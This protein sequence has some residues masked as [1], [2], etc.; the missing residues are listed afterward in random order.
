MR[1]KSEIQER[2]AATAREFWDLLSPEKPLFQG[3]PKVIHRGQADATWPLVPKLFRDH[4]NVSRLLARGTPDANT[5]MFGE[6][7]Y[8]ADFV[9]HCDSVGLTIPNDSLEFRTKYFDQNLLDRFFSPSSEWPPEGLVEL[10]ALAQHHGLPTRLLDWTKRSYVAAYFAASDALERGLDREPNSDGRF[11]V[12]ALSTDLGALFKELKIVPVPGSNNAN[13][14][15]QAGLFTILRLKNVAIRK[16]LEGTTFLDEYLSAQHPS[17]LVRVTVPV[18]EAPEVIR[19]CE[20]YH[21]TGATIFPEYY[22]AV[23]ASMDNWRQECWRLRRDLSAAPA[24]KNVLTETS[25]TNSSE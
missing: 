25:G 22:G 11:A 19:L 1:I 9:R 16:P 10:M 7:I 12:W 5:Q 20:T 13:L 4:N 17:A 8:L 24:Q 18:A 2:S 15:A 14:A 3:F 23:R 6:W 21:V